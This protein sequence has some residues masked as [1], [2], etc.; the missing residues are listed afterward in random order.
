VTRVS[1]G[2]IAEALEDALK[3]PIAPEL[4]GALPRLSNRAPQRFAAG[5]L[6]RADTALLR[7]EFDDDWFRNPRGLHALRELDAAPRPGKLPAESL[8]GAAEPLVQALEAM[9]G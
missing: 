4:V 2:A 1:R 7:G 3:V 6:A 8:R 5:L 9:S